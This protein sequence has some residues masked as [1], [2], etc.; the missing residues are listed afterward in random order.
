MGYYE[1]KICCDNSQRE[2]LIALLSEEGTLGII[3]NE[4]TFFCYFNDILSIDRIL[5]KIS[6]I[7][8]KVSST[9]D[10]LNVI[11][12]SYSYISERDW[13][14]SWKKKFVPIDIESTNFTIIAPWHQRNP[15]RLNLLI[16]PGMAFGTG[17]HETTRNCIR[18]INKFTPLV[19]KDSFLDL[20]T[21]TG[22]LAI[23][24]GILGFK[25]ITAIDNDPLAIDAARRNF[26][27]N[28]IN[29]INLVFGDI[30]LSTGKYDMIVANL[31]LNVL[32]ERGILISSL[33]KEGGIAL[34]SGLIDGQEDV[35]L[36]TLLEGGLKLLEIVRDGNWVSLVMTKTCCKNS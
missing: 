35:L 28:N 18:L 21:G 10:S 4:E 30:S 27:E 12:Y 5:S 26:R 1:I 25:L 11:N 32:S 34:I 2:P 36:P 3:D 8:T 33:L 19:N 7:I 15:D 23:C 20:G 13:N 31:L 29:N 24:A 9:F 14:E 22:I 17:H 16:D 6:N